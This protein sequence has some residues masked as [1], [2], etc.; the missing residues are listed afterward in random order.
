MKKLAHQAF[1]R[2]KSSFMIPE[3]GG[4]GRETLM[5]LNQQETEKGKKARTIYVFAPR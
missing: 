4:G 2:E 3:S 1:Q 5:I